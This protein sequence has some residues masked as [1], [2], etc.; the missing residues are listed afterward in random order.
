LVEE[1]QYVVEPGKAAT[2]E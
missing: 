1:G 2:D